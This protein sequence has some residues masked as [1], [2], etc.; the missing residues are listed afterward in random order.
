M[1]EVK[2]IAWQ[3]STQSIRQVL[4][5]D[6]LNNM[7]DLVGGEIEQ[8][9]EDVELMQYTGLKDKNGT[10]IYEGDVL[11]R[12]VHVVLH[13]TDL[14]KWIKERVVVDWKYSGWYVN[15]D[16]LEFVLDEGVDR[17][18]LCRQTALEVVG[19]IYENPELLEVVE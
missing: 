1:R 5:I 7:I 8:Y 11:E 17:H 18:T 2:F 6:Y 9:F 3:K 15:E 13:G 14:D 10:E 12:E 4:V 19:N 16:E